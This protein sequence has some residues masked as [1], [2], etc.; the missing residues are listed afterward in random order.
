MSGLD[1]DIDALYALPLAEFT[2]ARNALART[3]KGPAATQIKK[4]EK[5]T[6]IAWAVNQLYWHDRQV[7]QRLIQAGRALRTAQ[8]AAIEGRRSDLRKAADAHREALLNAVQHVTARAARSG[9]NPAPE[10][11]ARMLETVSLAEDLEH[12]GRFVEAI[13]PAGFEALLGVTPAARQGPTTAHEPARTGTRPAENQAGTRETARGTTREG[14]AAAAAKAAARRAAEQAVE[15]AER[16][17]E[18]AKAR[19]QRADEQVATARERL[20]DAERA[21]DTQDEQVAAARRDLDRAREA[22]RRSG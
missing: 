19:K 3:H 21:R 13:Q 1:A 20:A 22:L 4:L 5:P 14:E 7:W 10:Q 11:V 6:S 18:A 12:P 17:L 16:L 2:A 15:H 9:V 8:I